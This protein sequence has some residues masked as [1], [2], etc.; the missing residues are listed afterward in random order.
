MALKTTLSVALVSLVMSGGGLATSGAAD[1]TLGLFLQQEARKKKVEWPTGWVSDFPAVDFSG[2]WRF[3]AGHSDPMLEVWRGRQISYRIDQ[4]PSHIVLE[5]V[6]EGGHTSTQTYRWDGTVHRYEKGM[7]Q[8]EEIARW[9]GAGRILEVAGHR[10]PLN[11]PDRV[12][13]YTFR[14][15]VAADVLSFSQVNDTGTTVWKFV[16]SRS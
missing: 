3:D 8:V 12:E 9:T 13:S 4:Q 11:T 10:W 15:Q 2:S 16:R 6:V 1:S 7:T 14:Y 5:F